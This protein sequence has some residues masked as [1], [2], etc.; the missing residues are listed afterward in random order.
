MSIRGENIYKRKD[1]RYEGRYIKSYDL[2]GKINYGSVYAHTYAETKEKLIQAKARKKEPASGANITVSQWITSW[3]NS[4]PGIKESTRTVYRS[5]INNQIIPHIGKIRLNRL[6]KDTL[7]NFVL[8]LDLAPATTRAVF[9]V[10][11]AALISAEEKGYISNIWS[12]IRLQKKP[13]AEVKVLSVSEQKCLER[14]LTDDK[15]IGILI[16]L[17]TGLRIGE[18]CALRWSDIDFGRCQFHVNGTQTRSDTGIKVT[19]PKSVASVR[20]IPIPE[21]LV[22]KLRDMPR[23]GDYVLFG[24]NGFMDVRSYR[25]HFKKLLSVAH[26]PDIKFH[27]LRHTFATRALEVG[28]NFKTLSEI[29]GHSS[30]AITLNLYVHSLDEYKRSQMSKMGELYSPSK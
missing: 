20:T 27:A 1:G 25:R 22:K 26:L 11:K 23:N 18:L 8:S 16:S 10:L 7:Q 30:V 29:L 24:E 2:N 4:E 14:I 13:K 6:T 15:D 5:Y 9:T 28:M 12:K 17:Y 19:S 3:V 21:F